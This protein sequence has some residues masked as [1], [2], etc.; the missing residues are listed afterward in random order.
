M[1]HVVNDSGLSL[2][3]SAIHNASLQVCVLRGILGLDQSNT[4]LLANICL[5]GIRAAVEHAQSLLDCT[6]GIGVDVDVLLTD[7]LAGDLLNSI[8]QSDLV[9][10]VSSDDSLDSLQ[11]V[12][13][14]LIHVLALL[15]L[16][17]H[18]GQRISDVLALDAIAAASQ[19]GQCQNAGEGDGQK[20]LCHFHDFCLHN[21]E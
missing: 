21:Y 4:D 11:G 3:Q 16:D 14:S 15:D 9:G 17:A 10:G 18:L 13:S 2:E 19:N 5:L 1:L 7:D 12:L 20:L 8:V 6:S